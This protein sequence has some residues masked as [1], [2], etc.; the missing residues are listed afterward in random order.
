MRRLLEPLLPIGVILVTLAVPR[1]GE[2]DPL[3]FRITGPLELVGSP[4]ATVRGVYW[5]VLYA[6]SGRVRDVEGWSFGVT[7]SNLHVVSISTAGTDAEKAFGG[8]ELLAELTPEGGAI[9]RAAIS[10]VLP[11]VLDGAYRMVHLA[12]LRVEAEVA[13]DG[14]PLRARVEI[15]GPPS[16]TRGGEDLVLEALPMDVLVRAARDCCEARFNVG[17][18]AREI[19]SPAPFEGI[20]SAPGGRCD[21]SG[22]EILVP[23]LPGAV[24]ETEVYVNV[25]RRVPVAHWALAVGLDGEAVVWEAVPVRF[26]S[27]TPFEVRVDATR[28]GGIGG[29]ITVMFLSETE[30]ESLPATRS[31]LKLRV[32][33]ASPQ[34]HDRELVARLSLEDGL[35]DGGREATWNVFSE[36]GGSSEAPCNGGTASLTLRFTPA[37]KPSF[38]R[39]DANVDGRVDISDGVHTLQSFFLGGARGS[40]RSAADFDDSGTVDI[41]DAS[42]TFQNLFLGGRRPP[43][44][45]SVQCGPDPSADGLGCLELPPC[46]LPST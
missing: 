14:A 18:S 40:C 38:L 42:G 10:P 33:A 19:G 46:G 9:G 44:P 17:F 15:T 11:G 37:E 3:A 35:Q 30:A 34:P 12:I 5:C 21:G 23:V 20:L 31:L 6:S 28:N 29:A 26:A 41:S 25:V 2:G 1:V 13:S 32:R 27:G 4:G 45:G 43:A 8:G 39:G 22:G 16:A 36:D 7:P 24:G